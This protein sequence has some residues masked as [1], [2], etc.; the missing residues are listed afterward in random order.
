MTISFYKGLITNPEIGYTPVC[1][2]LNIWRLGQAKNTKFGTN[3]SN[4]MLLN[5]AKYQGY[6]FY[7]FWIIK[8]RP[9]GGGRGEELPTSPPPRLHPPPTHSD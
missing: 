1:V 9:T 7:Y 3:V 2:L 8:E 4:K 6:S 5:A